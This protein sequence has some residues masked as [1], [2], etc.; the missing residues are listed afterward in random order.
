MPLESEALFVR[1]RLEPLTPRLF[2]ELLDRGDPFAIKCDYRGLPVPVEE[3][4]LA[5]VVP[6]R[7][8]DLRPGSLVLDVSDEGFE[9]K[10]TDGTTMADRRRVARIVCVDRPGAH[11]RFD[12][13]RWH[14]LSRLAAGS[15]LAAALLRLW[16]AQGTPLLA[17]LCR[18]GV[19][20]I[21][22]GPA[23]ELMAQVRAKRAYG[24]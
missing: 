21:A 18:P 4:D 12:R 6:A 5:C 24:P 22:F 20:P 14:I 15:P 1:D 13:G 17:R 8:A 11:V 9:F 7:L 23:D 19:L 10:W 2:A 3:L 16:C